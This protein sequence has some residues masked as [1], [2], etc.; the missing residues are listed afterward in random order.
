MIFRFENAS[1]ENKVIYIFIS[2]YFCYYYI[3]NINFQNDRL[4][5]VDPAHNHD[6]HLPHRIEIDPNDPLINRLS[7]TTFS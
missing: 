5:N 3:N 1:N 4:H 6:F 2:F 7:A